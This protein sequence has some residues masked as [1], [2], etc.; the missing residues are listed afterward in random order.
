V[1]NNY[2]EDPDA[3]IFKLEVKM[4]MADSSPPTRVEDVTQN[5]A[6]SPIQTSY[7]IKAGELLGFSPNKQ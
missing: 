5:A 4:Q 6:I 7:I 1:G 2:S 3:S